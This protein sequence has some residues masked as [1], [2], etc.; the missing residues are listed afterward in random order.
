MWLHFVFPC[1]VLT[2]TWLILKCSHSTLLASRDLA[3]SFACG[4]CEPLQWGG[5]DGSPS[6]SPCPPVPAPPSLFSQG[7]ASVDTPASLGHVQCF[8]LQSGTTLGPWRL[9]PLALRLPSPL[10][11]LDHSSCCPPS[12][13]PAGLGRLDPRFPL[14]YASL[15]SP[16]HIWPHLPMSFLTLSP[17]DGSLL[18]PRLH[19]ILCFH[20]LL[21]AF[22]CAA[23]IRLPPS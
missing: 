2:L 20:S 9:P 1:S 22:A 13:V 3:R 21:R 23:S 7:G 12:H 19:D 6:L 16:L 4:A 17:T 15:P 5:S 11:F 10:H 8:M 14:L 18:P